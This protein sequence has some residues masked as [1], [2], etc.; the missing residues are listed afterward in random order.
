[1]KTILQIEDD[2]DDAFIFERALRTAGV[3]CQ[4]H[5]VSDAMAAKA[6][7]CGLS[8]YENRQQFP[9]PDLVVTDLTIHS[10]HAGSSLDLLV[11]LRAQPELAQL[12]VFCSTGSSHPP[13]LEAFANL[14]VRCYVKSSSMREIVGAVQ[15]FFARG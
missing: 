9:F 4:M 5:R 14:G 12:P 15:D 7:L 13:T 3:V 11:W 1:M 8:P 6:Y 2:A 10:P